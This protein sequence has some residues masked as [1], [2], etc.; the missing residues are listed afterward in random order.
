MANVPMRS[1]RSPGTRVSRRRSATCTSR[2]PRRWTRSAPSTRS[3]ETWGR[4]REVPRKTRGRTCSRE[5]APAGLEPA[6]G[7]SRKCSTAHTNS[8]RSTGPQRLHVV[9]RHDTS[10]Q[11][12][13]VLDR[14]RGDVGETLAHAKVLRK[15][16]H[17]SL[18]T[19]RRVYPE[20]R[21]LACICGAA[22][23]RI[24]G[25]NPARAGSRP[26]R[27]LGSRRWDSRDPAR[28]AARDSPARDGGRMARALRRVD[29]PRLG[30]RGDHDGQS[31]SRAA[32]DDW[33]H[34]AKERA[35]IETRLM[36]RDAG[37]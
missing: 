23:R 33:R 25:T 9:S 26:V 30:L 21:R 20:P 15:Q 19:A 14:A 10:Q 12:S 29:R 28:R 13:P 7:S 35:L 16:T 11:Q 34:L 1:R 4:R 37:R 24:D 27:P 36:L 3:P 31:P 5:V 32:A 2:T 18:Y 6:T 17:E 8:L 22:A